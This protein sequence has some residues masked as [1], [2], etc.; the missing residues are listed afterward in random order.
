MSI[1]FR[2]TG[3]ADANASSPDKSDRI[4][5]YANLA[6]FTRGWCTWCDEKPGVCVRNARELKRPVI[7]PYFDFRC[8]AA[9]GNCLRLPYV[10][11]H[12]VS[13]VRNSYLFWE[14]GLIGRQP[15]NCPKWHVKISTNYE[16]CF[17]HCF[18]VRGST[19][20]RLGFS[21]QTTLSLSAPAAIKSK[22][23]SPSM[24]A[25]HKS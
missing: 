24:S 21:S 16:A 18:C 23:P 15:Y 10:F 17:Y 19:L 11:R 12:I 2:Y 14:S 25:A 9:V 3:L 22:S 13:C 8:G 6:R 20:D 4:A 7:R 5:V 1:I